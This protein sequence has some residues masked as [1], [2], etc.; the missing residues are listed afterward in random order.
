VGEV[1]V[2]HLWS[3]FH[4]GGT[5]AR[6]VGP[7][8]PDHTFPEA[9]RERPVATRTIPIDR[10]QTFRY[11]GV[12]GGPRGDGGCGAGAPAGGDPRAIQPGGGPRA[13]GSGAGG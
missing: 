7:A 4:I 8:L 10:D 9:A 12:S 5:V 3:N 2:E 13:Q 1:L 11:A 6:D